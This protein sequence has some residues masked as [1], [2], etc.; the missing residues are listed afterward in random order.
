MF[1][2]CRRRNMWIAI[3]KYSPLPPPLLL[4]HWSNVVCTLIFLSFSSFT[5]HFCARLLRSIRSKTHRYCIACERDWMSMRAMQWMCC[6]ILWY[7]NAYIA[8]ISGKTTSNFMQLWLHPMSTA[9]WLIEHEYVFLISLLHTC[10]GKTTQVVTLD[11][12]RIRK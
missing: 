7:E 4:L 2:I 10:L 5:V 6:S 3:W 9:T 1:A 8:S 12:V 11:W